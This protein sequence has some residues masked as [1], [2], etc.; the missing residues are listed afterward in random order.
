MK[1]WR[2]NTPQVNELEQAHKGSVSKDH[3]ANNQKCEKD[4]SNIR[5]GTVVESFAIAI[6]DGLIDSSVSIETLLSTRNCTLFDC[7]PFHF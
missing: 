4:Y 7:F 2:R 6:L 3:F 1:F 5:H